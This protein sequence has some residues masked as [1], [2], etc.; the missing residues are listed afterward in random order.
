M[1]I[2][3]LLYSR[4][5]YSEYTAW[6][7][8]VIS[9]SRCRIYIMY[10]DILILLKRI[11]RSTYEIATKHRQP[12]NII[13][14]CNILMRKVNITFA[15]TRPPAT[16]HHVRPRFRI[17]KSLCPGCVYPPQIFLDMLYCVG[18]VEVLSPR[19]IIIVPFVY[20]YSEMRIIV[21]HSTTTSS[22][23]IK[24]QW[25]FSKIYLGYFAITVGAVL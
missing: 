10:K 8:Y 5:L 19:T 12:Y 25:L 1:R 24:I 11:L 14:Y 9:L 2:P 21:F 18:G 17:D 7:W 6:L 23:T 15:R 3:I 13:Y 22:A 16:T 20:Q 4:S